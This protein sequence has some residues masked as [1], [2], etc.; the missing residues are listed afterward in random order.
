MSKEISDELAAW[1]TGR[2]LSVAAR[3]LEHA[4]ERILDERGLTHAGLVALHCVARGA[5]YQREIA[6]QCRVTDQTMSRTVERLSQLGYIT[7]SR[8]AHDARRSTIKITDGGY[9][10]YRELHALERD[11]PRLVAGL[12]EHGELRRLLLQLLA[13][14]DTLTTGEAGAAQ[15]R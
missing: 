1:P 12:P 15:I 13:H 2:L 6:K 8:D 10:I 4:W 3:K 11:D 7:K 14:L 9:R 5:Q